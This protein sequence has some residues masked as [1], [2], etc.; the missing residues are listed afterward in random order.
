VAASCCKYKGLSVVRTGEERSSRSGRSWGV[1]A[2]LCSQGTA[3]QHISD[4]DIYVYILID[5]QEASHFR[6][7][8]CSTSDTGL[9][10]DRASDGT[11]LAS[12]GTSSTVTAVPTSNNDEMQSHFV[13]KGEASDG[14]QRAGNAAVDY[15]SVLGSVAEARESVEAQFP[16]CTKA[17]AIRCCRG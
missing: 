7:A 17:G 9:R 1:F 14:H 16:F 3:V 5:P 4:L 6:D 15:D 12:P 10:S 8:T 13:T 11:A 2:G